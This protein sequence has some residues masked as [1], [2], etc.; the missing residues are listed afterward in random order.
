[1]RSKQHQQGFTLVELIITVCIVAILASIATKEMRE[2]TRRA[3]VSEVMLALSKCKNVVT[4][5]FLTRDSAPAPGSWGCEG[6]GQSYYAAAVQTNSEGV[7]RV[8][9]A[10]LDGLVNGHYI[11]LIPLRGDGAQMLTPNDLGKNVSSWM[12]GS[13]WEPVRGALP[14]NCRID[15]TSYASGDFL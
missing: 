10:N 12:C 11:H 4:E 13:D 15:T 9:I 1:M 14:A 2:Y 7:V 6:T 8:A 5:N 3:K